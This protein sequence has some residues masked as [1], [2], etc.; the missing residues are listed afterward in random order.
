MR[1]AFSALV[2]IMVGCACSGNSSKTSAPTTTTA[3]P[4]TTSTVSRTV[5]LPAQPCTM[6]SP[7]EAG[8]VLPGSVPIARPG[9]RS[10]NISTAGCSWRAG[11]NSLD[12]E[13]FKDARTD[14]LRLYAALLKSPKTLPGIGDEAVEADNLT[15]K[16]PLKMVVILARDADVVVQITVRM[17]GQI[18][19][20]AV[21]T[22]TQAAISRLT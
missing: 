21:E 5:S 14:P 7:T 11:G 18:D 4:T 2:A 6:L 12:L 13:L 19:L 15:V 20:G 8:A 9:T 16:T 1:W 17:H 10:T 22:A 3:A